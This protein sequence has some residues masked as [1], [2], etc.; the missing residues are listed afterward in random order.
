MNLIFVL[1]MSFGC[2][3]VLVIIVELEIFSFVF[4]VLISKF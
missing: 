1:R 2:R 4:F 3:D